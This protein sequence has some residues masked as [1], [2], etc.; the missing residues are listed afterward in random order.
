YAS[1][2][3]LPPDQSLCVYG[4]PTGPRRQRGG[5]K[6]MSIRT[7]AAP[8][9]LWRFLGELPSVEARGRWRQ[10]G[11]CSGDER[12]SHDGY[13][14]PAR[15]RNPPGVWVYRAAF[16]NAETV[17]VPTTIELDG[18][19]MSHKAHRCVAASTRESQTAARI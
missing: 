3:G 5:T 2:P 9:V 16:R 12:R 18:V 7:T 11:E 1:V 6:R 4:S 10:R 8:P 19:R 13:E 14:R 15:S 17:A